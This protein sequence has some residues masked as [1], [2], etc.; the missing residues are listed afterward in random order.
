MSTKHAPK[1]PETVSKRLLFT[2]PRSLAA[3]LEKYA[4]VL[5]GG[6]KSGFVADAI[7][8]YI[9]HFRRRRHTQ[10]LRDAYAQAAARGQA[11]N[12]EWAPLDD[13]TWVRL[14]GLERHPPHRS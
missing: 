5:R 6:N 4:A 7:L 12:T 8:W 10:L 2:L 1:Q 3:E 9:D 11:V 14:D 13:E